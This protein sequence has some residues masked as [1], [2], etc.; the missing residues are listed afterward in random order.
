VRNNLTGYEDDIRRLSSE[1][2][3]LEV[4]AAR[5][6]KQKSRLRKEFKASTGIGL[7]DFDAARRLA[8]IMDMDDRQT[9]LNGWVASYNA[10]SEGETLDWV[11]AAI[12]QH[13]D[14][15]EDSPLASVG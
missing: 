11:N 6:N 12:A 3:E 15:T 9:K 13:G 8:E 10:L 1:L 14:I 5:I 4:E 2:G 7:G